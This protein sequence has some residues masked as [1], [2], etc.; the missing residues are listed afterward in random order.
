MGYR[1]DIRHSGYAVF[2]GLVPE[3]LMV[4]ARAAIAQDLRSNYDPSREDEYGAISYC[5]GL[6]STPAIA[7]LI[8]ASPALAILDELFGR[9]RF[10]WGEGQIAI[11]RAHNHERE[12]APDPHLDGFASGNNGLQP[13]RIYSH[14][15]LLGVF[16][17]RVTR[18]F[19]GNFAVWPGSHYQYAQYFRERG[20]RA[21]SEPMP[22]IELGEPVQLMSAIGDVVLA[23]YALGH[24]AA[25]NTSDADRIA[26][27][28]RVWLRSI[29][30]DRWGHLTDMWTGWHL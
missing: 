29:E 20:P 30:H 18:P 19:A 9:G 1:E 23:Q 5:P 26:V 4:T 15:A 6:R 16:L 2:P 17:T 12:V 13:G 11:R 10:R 14:T 21:M 7:N 24:S 22:V 27:F 25:V 8:E 3:S 28:F